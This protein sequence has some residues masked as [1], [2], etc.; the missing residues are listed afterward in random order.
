MFDTVLQDR[1][2]RVMLLI[3][4]IVAV[5]AGLY[6]AKS[7]LA[8][9]LFAIVVGVVVSPVGEKLNRIGVPHAATA[10]AVLTLASALIVLTFLALEPLLSAM[11][12]QL[13]KIKREIQSWLDNAKGLLQGIEQITREIEATMGSD[14]EETTPTAVPTVM[15]A[16]WLAPGFG[17]QVFIFVGTLFF[18][19]LTRTDLYKS[20]GTFEVNL[21]SADKA[22]SRYFSAVTLVNLGLGVAVAA[23]MASIGLNNALLWGLAA[24]ILN[25]ILYLGPLMILSGLLIA[26]M[27]QFSGATA[28]LPPFLF[29]CLN[30][31]EAQFVTPTVVGKRLAINPLSVFLA[32]VF[33]L[34]LWGPV[35]A[36]VALPVV[37]WLGVLL[38]NEAAFTGAR[39]KVLSFRSTGS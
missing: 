34:W 9:A 37:L 26:G 33:G 32:I 38:K 17:A 30:L 10:V 18:F 28:L 8:P 21:L 20:A 35:G 23:V 25:Y 19:V 7:V 4:T 22:V 29:M 27:I 11:T 24:G 16:L 39:R 13:P 36:I 15:D 6:L 3:V 1:G 2:S 5:V 12:E 31:I 14:A